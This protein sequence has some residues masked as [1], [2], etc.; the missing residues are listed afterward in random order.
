MLLQLFYQD[1]LALDILDLLIHLVLGLGSLSLRSFDIP[2]CL[3]GSL[4]PKLDIAPHLTF[5]LLEFRP[6]SRVLAKHVIHLEEFGILR[7][8]LGLKICD[9][10]RCVLRQKDGRRLRDIT[11]P[12][13]HCFS[14]DS[15]FVLHYDLAQR[16]QRDEAPG[17]L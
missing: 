3:L 9:S 11:C 7:G 15:L 12:P 2:L 5:D 8:K 16:V 6:P 1:I 10:S 14:K 17:E 13:D 4:L